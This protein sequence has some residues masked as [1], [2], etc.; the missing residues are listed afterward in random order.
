MNDLTASA[1]GFE[2]SEAYTCTECIKKR[3]KKENNDQEL[4]ERLGM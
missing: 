3:K 1:S 4:E 2:R